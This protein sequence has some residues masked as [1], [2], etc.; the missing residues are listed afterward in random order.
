MDSL[1]QL[2]I[3]EISQRIVDIQE[4]TK[5]NTTA[6][7]TELKDHMLARHNDHATLRK[8]CKEIAEQVTALV[9]EYKSEGKKERDRVVKRVISQKLEILVDSIMHQ[10]N[11]LKGGLIK[12]KREYFE[13][14]KEIIS[15]IIETIGKVLDVA[16][17]SHMFYPFVIKMSRK[18]SLLSMASGSFIPVTYYP[19]HM[20]S[21]MAKISSSSV[22]VQP[23]PENAIKVTDRY[24]IS[25]VYNDYVMN[26]CL[27]IIGEC[28]KQYAN[29]LSFPEY[30]AYIVVELKRI[31]NSQNKC[32]SWVN[33][34]IEGIIKAVKA[35]TERIQSI[36][37]GITSTDVSTIRKVEEKIPA[38]QMNIE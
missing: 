1:S 20:M 16:I 14:S 13:V 6:M 19:M 15:T 27:D 11:R 5:E 7:C 10:E 37:E 8:D 22:P 33:S 3:S 17:T 28:I 2:S 30:S 26:N 12:N 21:Q 9:E 36:R 34:K 32:S 35:H 18:L 29:S 24:I 4:N 23:V 31:R 25:N 38:F